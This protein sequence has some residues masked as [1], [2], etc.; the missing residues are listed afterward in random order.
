MF[1]RLLLVAS[2]L[3]IAL[4]AAE[5]VLP[6]VPPHL[7]TM[8]R[9]VHHV[10]KSGNYYL[11]PGAEV[12]FSGMFESISP[13]VMWQVN[14]QGFRA[15]ADAGPPSDRFRISTYGDSETF[16]WSVALDDTFQ[17]RME[18]LD[19]AVE[20]LN[21]GIPGYNAENVADRVEATLSTYSPDMLL[22]LVNKNDVDLP[23]DISDA[24]LSSDLLLRLRFFYQVALSKPWR[25]TMRRSPERLAF[26]AAQ[27]DRIERYAQQRRVPVM[28]AFMKGYTW[29]GAAEQ[30][31][32]GGFV[33]KVR[34]ARATAGGND[35][36]ARIVIVDDDL[37]AFP[38]IDDHLPREAHAVLAQRL[39]TAI[40][41]A[42]G[43][44]CVPAHW[45]A[46]RRETV[47][48]IARGSAEAL[49]A[50]RASLSGREA[51]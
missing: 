32:P 51:K 20:V 19:P 41:G 13:A 37:R 47:P 45:S 15:A 18:S 10:D 43:E 40:S 49:L 25:Q 7:G 35:D 24:V 1:H 38:R 17:R 34:D 8:Q 42:A 4:V 6:L 9:I 14:R 46:A 39:C 30:A 22:Y 48:R 12:P 28:F 29:E 3:V 31:Q 26:L 50:E 44:A 11:K 5:I 36:A 27:I 21:F 16:G 2:A 33:A 23:N